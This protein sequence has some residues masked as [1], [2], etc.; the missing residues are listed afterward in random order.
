MS[1]VLRAERQKTAPLAQVAAHGLLK[2]M[3]SSR[4]PI[5]V[6]MTTFGTARRNV[7]TFEAQVA[8]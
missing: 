8:L 3:L 4:L 7:P 5:A 2:T 6:V 1:I